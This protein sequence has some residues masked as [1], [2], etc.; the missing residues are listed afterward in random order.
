MCPEK[1]FTPDRLRLL[2]DT[3]QKSPPAFGDVPRKN[4]QDR[5][6]TDLGQSSTKSPAS[7]RRYTAEK[8]LRPSASGCLFLS[9]ARLPKWPAAI[10]RK[11]VAPDSLRLLV[12]PLQKVSP[13]SG[14]IPRKNVYARPLPAAFSHQP[15]GLSSDPLQYPEKVQLRTAFDFWLILCKKPLQPSE[16]YPE[17]TFTPDRLRLLANPLQKALPAFGDIPR[18]NVYA[19]LPPAAF[20]H[21]PRGL[22]SGLLRWLEKV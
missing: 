5:L 4:I 19:R 13:A 20:S 3:L 22:S 11:S 12:D 15:R 18:K 2:V 14:D 9:T 6:P 7:L 16:I 8:C 17:K 10:T 1:T 21:R